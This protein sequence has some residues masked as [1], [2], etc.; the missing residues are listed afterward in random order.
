MTE[1]PHQ[2]V[3]AR[4]MRGLFVLVVFG[5][6]WKLGGLL[7]SMIMAGLFPPGATLDA[8]TEVFSVLIF[9]FLYSSML[10]VVVPAFMPLFAEEREHGGEDA[11]WRLANTVLN[12]VLIV[13]AAVVAGAMVFSPIIVETLVPGFDQ[14]AKDAAAGMLRGMMPGVMVMFF[15]VVALGILNSYKVFSYPAA[16]DAV[17]KLTWAVVLYAL[18]KTGMAPAADEK[19][20]Y[21]GFLTGALIQLVVLLFGMRGKLRRYRPS[22][23][24]LSPARIGKELGLVL[25]AAAVFAGWILFLNS[26]VA[27]SG[28]RGNARFLSIV[29]G[30][31]MGFVYA[32][33]LWLRARR[34]SGLMARFAVLAAP[35]LIGVIFARFRDLSTAFFQSYTLTGVFGS[36]EL[37]KKIGNLPVVLLAYSL[38]IAMFPYL[39]DL[40]VRKDLKTFSRLLTGTVHSIALLAVPMTVGIIVLNRPIMEVVFDRGNWSEEML[41]YGGAALAFFAS[42]LVF[43]ALENVIMQSSFSLKR[44][45]TPTITG[46]IATVAHAL[47]LFVAIRSLGYDAPVEIFV[48]V[49]VSFPLSR[50]L[51]NIALMVILRSHIDFLPVKRTAVFVA[52]LLLVSAGVGAAAWFTLKPIQ[53]ILPYDHLRQ[54]EVM[55]DTFNLEARGWF[56]HHIG[57]FKVTRRNLYAPYE[58]TSHH[59]TRFY[60]DLRAYDLRGIRGVDITA[61][62]WVWDNATELPGTSPDARYALIVEWSDGRSA[63]AEIHGFGTF[64]ANLSY[65]GGAAPDGVRPERLVIEDRNGPEIPPNREFRLMRLAVVTSETTVLI[66]DFQSRQSRWTGT[67]HVENVAKEGEPDE[68]ALRLGEARLDLSGYRLDGCTELRFKGKADAPARL[69]LR[70]AGADGLG[71]LVEVDIGKSEKRKSYALTLPI[72]ADT[73]TGVDL[74]AGQDVWLDNIAFVRPVQRIPYELRKMITLGVPTV[75]GAITFV[76]LCLLLRVREALDVVDWV[77]R[78]GWRER[79]MVKAEARAA[80]AGEADAGPPAETPE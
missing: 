18:I 4:I 35:L 63:E 22:L 45:W 76:L 39:C 66:D 59:R 52:K 40:A 8:Y 2:N 6:F 43:Y 32:G 58:A 24:G 31:V 41:A 30:T 51:K 19:P 47:F 80:T 74:H 50:A 79:A 12:L 78:R 7:M 26:G 29:G 65:R 73:I 67:A 61:F 72:P 64:S 42:G 10:K 53:R 28:M 69:R 34:R 5:L 68:Y 16:G 46:M 38:S 17:Q 37:A 25:V 27:P 56:S 44:M 36:M 1:H 20:I 70:F 49:A 48:V 3:A 13:G 15:A 14:Q 55:I 23:G 77:K 11:A 71:E 9:T 62:P 54:R 33:F 60:R 57:E 75:A 21:L